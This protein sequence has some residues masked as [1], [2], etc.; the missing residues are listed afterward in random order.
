MTVARTSHPRAIYKPR[1]D[2][3]MRVAFMFIALVVGTLLGELL[4][5]WLVPGY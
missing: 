3:I 1:G 5:C 4:L 2:Q